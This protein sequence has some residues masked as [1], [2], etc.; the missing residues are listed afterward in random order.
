MPFI[1]I[2]RNVCENK[3][4]HF[5][6]DLQWTWGNFFT[7]DNDTHVCFQQFKMALK[8]QFQ[9]KSKC[10]SVQ[11]PNDLMIPFNQLKSQKVTWWDS[12]N[13]R[14]YTDISNPMARSN[15]TEIDTDK[16]RNSYWCLK[17]QSWSEHVTTR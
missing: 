16:D 6:I 1:L 14:H 7:N 8:F 17:M 13:P 5:L 9:L 12:K 10:K 11:F 15:I 2:S 4:I 3:I